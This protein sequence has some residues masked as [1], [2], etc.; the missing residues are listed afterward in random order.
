MAQLGDRRSDRSECY[1]VACCAVSQHPSCVYR[2]PYPRR[3]NRQSWRNDWVAVF[4]PCFGG[5]AIQKEPLN[6]LLA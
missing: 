6:D 3:Q 1:R 4:I 5:R 2:K